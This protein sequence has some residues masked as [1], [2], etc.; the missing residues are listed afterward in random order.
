MR[1][2]K[3][4]TIFYDELEYSHRTNSSEERVESI[5]RSEKWGET[6]SELSSMRIT[7][8]HLNATKRI[9][10]RISLRRGICLCG[11]LMHYS[12]IR[13]RKWNLRYIFREY[14]GV[15]EMQDREK[16]Q[17]ICKMNRN[18]ILV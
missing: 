7:V 11:R 2:Q 12:P 15:I 17:H 5:C 8:F 10:F 1:L 6:I 18:F 9:Y 3:H 13:C 16:N 4:N 14:C